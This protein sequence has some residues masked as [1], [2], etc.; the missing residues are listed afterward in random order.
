MSSD[1]G[2]GEEEEWKSGQ[3]MCKMI[4]VSGI[5]DMALWNLA[6]EEQTYQGTCCLEAGGAA[7]GN[8]SGIRAVRSAN[9][10]FSSAG[11]DGIIGD[12]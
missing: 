1:N 10:Q 2:K 4:G 9:V 8:D 11:S 7:A 5:G 12:V 3:A 6:I